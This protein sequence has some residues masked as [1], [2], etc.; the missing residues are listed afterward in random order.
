ME[1]TIKNTISRFKYT[2]KYI[3][4]LPCN[5]STQ[6]LIANALNSDVYA[7]AIQKGLG[8]VYIRFFQADYHVQIST[9]AN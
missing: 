7:Q 5:S 4:D 9:I 6:S 8:E 3:T 2:P 1:T